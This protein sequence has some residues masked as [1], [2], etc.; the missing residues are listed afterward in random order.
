[1]EKIE[2]APERV[3]YPMPCSLVGA[4]VS[5]KP[6]YLTVAWFTMVNPK[7]PCVLVAMNKAHFTNAGVKENR[8][9]SINIPSADIADRTDYCGLVSGHR[10]DKSK[11]FETFYG[12]LETA[13]M[14]KECA[15]NVECKLIQTVDMPVEELFIGEI[16]A[17]YSE[18]RYLTD[19][20]P[21]LRKINPLLLVQ[22]QRRYATLGAD[23]G[24]AWGIGNALKTKD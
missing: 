13:P 20:L 7:P 23:I 5:G 3:Y 2:V 18:E 15:C 9:F 10:F 22:T 19:G 17:V 21:D 12:K 16:A 14:I 4:N 11:V 6:N 1:M 24:Q 8:T